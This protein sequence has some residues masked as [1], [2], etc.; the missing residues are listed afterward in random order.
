MTTRGS[1]PVHALLP[2]AV[3]REEEAEWLALF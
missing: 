2:S 3:A 1:M